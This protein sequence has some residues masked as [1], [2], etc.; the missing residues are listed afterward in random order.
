MIKIDKT[1]TLVTLINPHVCQPEKQQE[2]A[3]LLV[4]AVNSIYKNAEGFISA[5]VHRSEDGT[6][7]TNYAQYS[8]RD[9]VEGM[10]KANPNIPAFAKKVGAI[11]DSFDPH[12]H[13]VVETVAGETT[14]NPSETAIIS[15]QQSVVTLIDI[16][17][18]QPG[19]QQKLINALAEAVKTVDRDLS[20]FVSASI[21]K[22][23]DGKSVAN[24]EQWQ[25]RAHFEAVKE[26]ETAASSRQKAEQL[27]ES[28]DGKHII[29]KVFEAVEV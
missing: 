29:Y 18:C 21:H 1:Q 26:D 17:S 11:A 9:A 6:R 25:S 10:W 2:L 20:G 13:E 5:S 14:E 7:V 27:A 15:K 3:E 28:F 4:E 23:F 12:L 24:Y 19:N 8:S 22:S 16:Y